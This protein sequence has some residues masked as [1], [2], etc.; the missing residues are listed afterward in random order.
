MLVNYGLEILHG[1]YPKSHITFNDGCRLEFNETQCLYPSLKDSYTGVAVCEVKVPD[2]CSFPID[3][4]QMVNLDI[5]NRA[6]AILDMYNISLVTECSA[7]MN[8]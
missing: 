3:T 7:N 8:G 4:F 2:D 6:C 1:F 5:L